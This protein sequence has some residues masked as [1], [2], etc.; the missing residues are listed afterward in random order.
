MVNTYRY[1]TGLKVAR[2]LFNML[3]KSFKIMSE[4]IQGILTKASFE[5]Q[6]YIFQI[7]LIAKKIIITITICQR[8]LKNMTKRNYMTWERYVTKLFDTIV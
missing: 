1:I 5:R 8:E 3:S 6:K 7:H 2:N 4:L